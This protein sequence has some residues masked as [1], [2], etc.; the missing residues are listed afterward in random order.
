[1]NRIITYL[2][3]PAWWFTAVF[4]AIIASIVAAFLKDAL[5]SALS[6]VSKTYK[7]RKQNRDA[8]VEKEVNEYMSDPTLLILTF[9]KIIFQTCAFSCLMTIYCFATFAYVSL[10]KDGDFRIKLMLGTM[11]FLAGAGVIFGI[12]RHTPRVRVMKDAYRKYRANM[13]EQ[14]ARQKNGQVFSESARN[15]APKEPSS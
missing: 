1:M 15:V 13:L 7:T 14:K 10:P 9:C 11:V 3:D 4:I 6:K 5:L 8:D 2:S 12:V